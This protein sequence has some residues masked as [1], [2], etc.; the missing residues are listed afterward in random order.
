[1]TLKA[2]LTVHSFFSEGAGVSSPTQLVKR[3]RELGYKAIGLV[4]DQSMAG[5]VEL[6]QACEEQGLLPIHGST[7]NITAEVLGESFAAPL[8]ILCTSRDS[9]A[10]LNS[11]ITQLHDGQVVQP[12]DLSGKGFRVLTG[13][14]QGLLARLLVEGDFR[15]ARNWVQHLKALLGGDI[16][17]QLWHDLYQEDDSL[18]RL[19]CELAREEGI[20]CML[21]PEVRYATEDQWIVHDALVCARL[22]ITVM[23][24]H[25]LRPQNGEQCI[26]DPAHYLERLPSRKAAHTANL[27]ARSCVFHLLPDKLELANAA[28]PEGFSPY[29]WLFART[30]TALEERY[31][32]ELQQ[33]ASKR[34]SYEL[35]V[36]RRMGMENFFLVATEVMDFCKSRGILA[37]GRGS[38]AGSIV[39]YLLGITIVDPIQLDLT[40][41][42]FLVEGSKSTPDIDIDISSARRREVL[43][44]VEERFGQDSCEAM[45]CNRITYR[46][47]SALQDLS[48]ALGLPQHQAN[49]L[50][51]SLG[52]DY[53]HLR[54][55]DA[56]KAQVIF[57]EVLGNSPVKGKLIDVL[58]RM[59][60]KTVRHL[61]PHSGGVILARHPL[62]HYTPQRRSSGG[63]RHI[64]FDKDDAESLGLVKLDL[65]GLRMLSALENA[66]SEIERIED[67]KLDLTTLKDHPKVWWRISRGDTL[68]LFQIESPG[69]IQLSVRNRPKNMLELA[70]QIALFRPG[71]ITSS[72]VHPYLRRRAGK[73][74]IT[75]PHPT[76]QPIL[77]RTYGVILYQEQILRVCHDF[78]GLD[79]VTADRYRKRLAKW[80]DP[81]EITLLRDEFVQSAVQAH[82]S[83]SHPV[84]EEV[85][86][87]VFQMCEKFKGYGFPESHAASFARHTYASAFLREFFAAE[88]ITGVL[89]HE[90]GMYARS[91]VLQEAARHGVQ[92]L[93]LHIQCSGALFTVEVTG[94]QRGKPQKSIRFGFCGVKGLSE[95]GIQQL[96]LERTRGEFQTLEDFFV[97]VSLTSKEYEAL[98]IAGAFDPFLERREAL[99]QLKT[100]LNS[101]RGGSQA[102]FVPQV[103]TPVLQ[104]LSEREIFN[105]NQAL[106]HSQENGKHVMDFY[107]EELSAMGVVP[108]STL[109][110]GEKVCTAGLVTQRQMPPTANGVAFY[111]LESSHGQVQVVIPPELW[112]RERVVLRDAQ[113]LVVEGA[114]VK[115][116][117]HTGITAEGVWC[118]A[119]RPARKQTLV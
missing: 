69:Q 21:S 62:H 25:P 16:F 42:R 48:R 54:P 13:S 29:L 102:L 63:I 22:G 14:R 39:C 51:K 96:V 93:P 9:Y 101:V 27:L 92:I 30:H 23:D 89:N 44:W 90:P 26:R 88:F 6:A 10:E 67:I 104:P 55:A 38:A 71:P 12:A 17:I 98:V 105:W 3:A 68:T 20:E 2:L 53:R 95:T 119:R 40:F 81:E 18:S 94:T 31:P 91:T 61:A 80:E 117:R 8:V 33:Q 46:L 107:Q 50:T 19:T 78:A 5:A 110:D 112:D 60:R 56:A 66:L 100:L 58:S 57:D 82:Q 24:P 116:G 49:E 97:R 59:D 118:W 114:V 75:Y 109:R 35:G 36:I 32:P 64:E 70:H 47:S 115:R 85:A 113:I 111:T 52:R 15:R 34:L 7:L 87:E 73:E 108:L 4:D 45:V 41:E 74:E 86:L 72:T 99:F 76:L 1:M 11:L 84:T 77:S 103:K 37:S 65:L 83:S 79:W 43:S 28:I 106:K